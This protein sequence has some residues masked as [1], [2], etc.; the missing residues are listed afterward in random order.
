M[1]KRLARATFFV[2]LAGLMPFQALGQGTPTPE[3]APFF[4]P[5]RKP[6]RPDLTGIR[7]IRFLTDDDYPPF[8]FPG[9]DGQLTGFNVDLARAICFE[10]KVACTI[11]ARRWETLIPALEEGR[12]DAII[13]SMRGTE[14]DR[15]RIDFGIPYYRSPGRF[16]T[17]GR[18][19]QAAE[20]TGAL[21]D[22]TV[23]AL[24]GKSVAVASGTAHAAFLAAFFPKTLVKPAS[25][26]TEALRLLA[27][28]EADAVFGDGVSLAL[29]LNSPE[30]AGC[31]RF[32]G[33]SYFESR[34]FGPGAMI[35]FRKDA[36]QLRRA[37][38]YALFRLSETGVYQNLVL[39][40]FPVS[41][42]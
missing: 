25:D 15:A 7:A 36:P 40:Y 12:G 30:G 11:Q 29:W 33:G 5:A 4:D 21:T 28:G 14:A 22:A 3:P 17:R 34:Y 42:Y 16:V 13:A 27:R 6:E 39:K 2:C 10:L 24:A 8:H 37:T 1:F 19:G 18:D 35:G 26:Q 9:P 20:K 41:F 32:L 23:S 38:D 31:C